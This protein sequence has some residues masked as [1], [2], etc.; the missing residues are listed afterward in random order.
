VFCWLR[1]LYNL[2]AVSSL[3]G[4]IFVYGD[5]FGDVC[6]SFDVHCNLFNC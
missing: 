3:R 4:R 5:Y 1:S 2:L 6:L